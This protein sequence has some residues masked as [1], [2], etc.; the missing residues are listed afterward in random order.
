MM[1]FWK[2]VAHTMRAEL[3]IYSHL[4]FTLISV[5]LVELRAVN[6]QTVNYHSGNVNGAL[7]LLCSK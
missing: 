7:L 4:K 2:M 1:A 3:G 6:Y 5:C